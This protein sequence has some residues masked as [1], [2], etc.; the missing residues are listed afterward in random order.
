MFFKKK[1][2][3]ATH[4]GN[5]HLDDVFSIALLSILLNG[6]IKVV[7]TR[8]ENIISKADFVV[9]VGFQYD[10]S[11]NRFDHHQEG[12]AGK[13]ESGINYSAFG[14]LWKEYGEKVCGSKKIADILDK[15]L[16][17]V[18]DANDNGVDLYKPTIDGLNP[19]FLEDV[20]KSIKPTWKEE[21]LDIDEIFLDAVS[22]ANNF[23][24]RLIKIT[25]D[26]I[27]AENII[28][29]IYKSSEDKRIIVFGETYFPRDLLSNYPGPLFAVYKEKDGSRWRVTTLRE[30]EGSF[31]SRKNFPEEWWGKSREDLVKIT[32]ISEITFCRNGGVFAG[33][34]TKEGAIKL[35]KLA[36]D[37]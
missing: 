36:V 25:K 27:E 12:G 9:D 21:Y 19:L 31:K 18:I 28:D 6:N 37:N 23:L 10:P 5:F 3:V 33:A 34:E 14:I 32:G 4:N 26:N 2:V 17:E 30:S 15:K 24:V 7:R 11:K 13:R 1:I 22:I 35:A 29:E 16:V 20:I 8:D